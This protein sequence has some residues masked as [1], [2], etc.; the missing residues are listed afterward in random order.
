[1]YLPEVG[2][3]TLTR[4][5]NDSDYLTKTMIKQII[6][7]DRVLL[8][9]N[10]GSKLELIREIS[11]KD[12]GTV[13]FSNPVDSKFQYNILE[14]HDNSYDS[15]DVIEG[16]VYLCPDAALKEA[17]RLSRNSKYSDFEV[18]IRKLEVL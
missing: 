14:I 17:G 9:L 5:Y 16:E 4:L 8:I 13:F 10:V 7:D 3:I 2:V 6:D 1:M 18:V 15:Q 12:Y 11:L